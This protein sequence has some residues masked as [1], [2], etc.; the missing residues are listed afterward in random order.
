[1]AIR[2]SETS[3]NR[4]SNITELHSRRLGIFINSALSTSN[5]A[6]VFVFI[7]NPHP[8]PIFIEKEKN[9]NTGTEWHLREV[10]IPLP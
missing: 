6:Q 4:L 5:L 8:I 9:F 10:Y 7:F 2:S 1:M 3:G